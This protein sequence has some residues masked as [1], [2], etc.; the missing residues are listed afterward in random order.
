MVTLTKAN[1]SIP[2]YSMLFFFF[3]LNMRIKIIS[4]MENEL[5]VNI[6]LSIMAYIMEM[7][8]ELVLEVTLYSFSVFLLK[9]ETSLYR[10]YKLKENWCYRSTD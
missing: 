8:L 2:N 9:L 7:P 1:H 5:C 6:H 10:K 4:G 3:F